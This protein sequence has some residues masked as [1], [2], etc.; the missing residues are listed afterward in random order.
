MD[1]DAGAICGGLAD[2]VN[3]HFGTICGGQSNLIARK[4]D[5][6]SFIGGGMD[7]SVFSKYSVI[8]GGDSNKV[9]ING[10]YSFIGG[11]HKNFV[12]NEYSVVGGGY[13]NKATGA[14][15]TISGGY[16]NKATAIDVTIGGGD[17]NEAYSHGATIAGGHGN[18]VDTLAEKSTI[19]GGHYNVIDTAGTLSVISG[20]GFNYIASNY[21]AIAGGCEDSIF[22]GADYSFAFGQRVKVYKDHVAAFFT[23]ED[24]WK[25]G[26]LSV[27]DPSPHSNLQCN[28][29]FALP[30]VEVNSTYHITEK[31]FTV[32]VKSD[33]LIIWL[34]SPQNIKG[35]I[36]VIKST[37]IGPPD[38]YFEVKTPYGGIDG[39]SD[40]YTMRSNQSIMV[41]SNNNNR[42]W[43]IEERVWW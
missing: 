27:N 8:A 31:D 21:S 13:K 39:A 28:G 6:Y 1:G 30:I 18:L 37:Y 34:P 33:A 32:V 11:G 29:S 17:F 10:Y 41:Q 2:T 15:S 7:N 40:T 14:R 9:D 5:I 35:R 12:S 36:Y 42:W 20:G 19:C 38:H 43:I 3:G 16:W 4:E 22:A 23:D 24:E 25:R 26:K